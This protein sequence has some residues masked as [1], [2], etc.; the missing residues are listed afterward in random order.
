MLVNDGMA[1]VLNF[2]LSQ[3]GVCIP[4]QTKVSANPHINQSH[5]IKFTGAECIR[6]IEH[7]DGIIDELVMLAPV[8]EVASERAKSW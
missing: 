4:K 2:I 8:H 5:R 1:K 7:W 6:L 3:I